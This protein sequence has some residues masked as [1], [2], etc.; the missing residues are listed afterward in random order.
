MVPEQLVFMTK[1]YVKNAEYRRVFD[2]AV[3]KIGMPGLTPHELRHTCASLA[4]S[5][6][7]N[8]LAVQKLLGH[9]TAAMTLGLYA[10]LFNDDLTNVAKSLDKGAR[11]ALRK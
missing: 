10:H 5:S 3:E 1:G 7:A 11:A 6:G 4:I 9:E 8:I 2:L